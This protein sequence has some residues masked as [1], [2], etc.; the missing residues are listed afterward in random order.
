MDKD[1]STKPD[2][3]DA[4]KAESETPKTEVTPDAQA[5]ADALSRT[6][7]DLEEEA[8]RSGTA[9]PEDDGIKK[10][11]PWRRFWRKVN[12]YLLAFVLI[13]AVSVIISVVLYLNSTKTPEV[14]KV[15]S[16]ELTQDALKQLANTDASVGNTN[17][18]L[19]IKGNA[20]I[21]GQTLMRG[22]LNIAGNL[23]TGGSIRGPSIAI[24]GNANLGSAQ[25]NSLQI[26]GDTAVQG[27]TTLR[28]LNV[29]G[30]SSFSGPVTA[31]DMTVTKLTLSGNAS[32]TVPN[33]IS[34]PGSSPSRTNVNNA[35]LGTGGSVSIGGSD[36][37]GTVN[38]NTGNNPTPGCFA[39]FVF[40]QAFSKSPYVLISPVSA[41]AGQTQFYTNRTTT[42]FEICTAN[43]APANQTFAYDYLI[44][45]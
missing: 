24:S 6:P 33:H 12:V 41:G 39:R 3:E 8:E 18:T 30:T 4:K 43:S 29:S 15:L 2:D 37:A 21:D 7:E 31:G 36:T 17:Q 23:Q 11:S 9:K 14:P 45:N 13:L 27:N 28:N 5:P 19:T 26:A 1:K 32:L 34:F 25:I 44:T 20:I 42:Y 40:N 16:Q 22:D 10:L 35:A 38:V